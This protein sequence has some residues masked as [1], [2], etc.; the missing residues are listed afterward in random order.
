[1]EPRSDKTAFAAAILLIGALFMGLGMAYPA[2]AQDRETFVF[3]QPPPAPERARTGP[4]GPI[5]VVWWLES[6]GSWSERLE[7]QG[8]AHI[9]GNSIEALLDIPGEDAPIVFKTL[10]GPPAGE[11]SYVRFSQLGRPMTAPTALASHGVNYLTRAGRSVRS[12]GHDGGMLLN[13]DGFARIDRAEGEL[14]ITV[15]VNAVSCLSATEPP[16]VSVAPCDQSHQLSARPDGRANVRVCIVARERWDDDPFAC[17]PPFRVES[18]RPEPERENVNFETPDLTVTFSEPVT[19]PSLTRAFSLYTYA[20]DGDQLKIEG[21]WDRNGASGYRFSPEEPLYSGTIY[22][23]RIESG[24]AGVLTPEGAML[25]EDY[26]WS[27]VT[28]LDLSVQA[29]EDES[30]VQLHTFQVVRNAFL[31]RD[32]PT[33][34]RAY[35]TWE[36]HEDVA[37]HMQPDSFPMQLAYSEHHPRIVGQFRRAPRGRTL[38]VW[39]H[40]DDDIFSHDDRRHARHTINAFGWRPGPDSGTL[41]LRI[42]PDDPFPQ[43]L[44][45]TR[46][47]AER[48]YDV[49][50]L[51][52]GELSVVYAVLRIGDWLDGIPD[53]KRVLMLNSVN[54]ASTYVPQY[55]PHR[56]TR[57]RFIRH[58]LSYVH[59]LEALLRDPAMI[60]AYG[61]V[62]V[63]RELERI[64]AAVEHNLREQHSSG[65]DISTPGTWEIFRSV[66]RGDAR[67]DDSE[68]ESMPN[69]V[70]LGAFAR[71]VQERLGQELGPDDM[72]AIITPPLFLGEATLGRAL[73]PLEHWTVKGAFSNYQARSIM[74]TM[75]AG[76]TA[77]EL[78][79]GLVHEFA[80]AFGLP[81]L[82]GNADQVGAASDFNLNIEAYRIA[83]SG[84]DGWNKSATEGNAQD[85][86]TLVSLMWPSVLPSAASSMHMA[87][88]RTVQHDIR[89]GM[90]P[91]LRDLMDASLP[92]PTRWAQARPG[93]TATDAARPQ[94]QS[95]AIS[96]WM[97]ADD[98]PLLINPVRLRN[99]PPVQSDAGRFRAVLRDD[100]GRILSEMRF[101]PRPVRGLPAHPATRRLMH[102]DNPLNPLT[103]AD[104]AI[105]LPLDPD[106]AQIEILDGTTVIA[107]LAPQIDGPLGLD[108]S[109]D[110]SG[111]LKWAATGAPVTGADIHYS[112]TGNAPWKPLFLHQT[113]PQIELDLTE[114]SDGPA[115]RLRVTVSDGL[116]FAQGEVQLAPPNLEWPA[117][118]FP[119]TG[120]FTDGAP[121]TLY[122][123]AAVDR[124][125]LATHLVVTDGTGQELQTELVVNDATLT[126]GLFLTDDTPVTGALTLA[127]GR[128]LSSQYGTAI[129]P[130]SWPVPD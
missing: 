86:N 15:R 38:R 7:G 39:R 75:N 80:H 33:L 8:R 127:I 35:V 55:L 69:T 36:R 57:T 54:M 107:A 48:E 130:I 47:S 104:F 118:D 34:T 58:S 98:G 19:L 17:D 70:L 72:L 46:Y 84:L 112:P 68:W 96:G 114:L 42:E 26:I 63:M 110:P 129:P 77:D 95:L 109:L 37:H 6:D 43:P 49:W 5:P 102:L 56:G 124:A 30:P 41:R 31:T 79:V 44:E 123:P 52:P 88:Y 59:F 16:F 51:D 116:R 22:R 97:A 78:G 61:G 13:E 113:A 81:H 108:L 28:M 64:E 29:P 89:D 76:F 105:S 91:G 92:R 87:E 120:A 73:S 101:D 4:S 27:F 85:E 32:K 83:P 25:D 3:E 117:P 106:A 24:G 20:P 9:V 122:L 45:Q 62:L 71:W 21:T 50:E 128:G 126:A 115:P 74:M 121:I 1:M 103:W 11:T 40:D 66:R 18:V 67:Y 65:G 82:P 14:A 60:A 100:G 12:L 90:R 93:T 23:A 2:V 53:D 111:M 10:G 119:D 99:A 94:V 125:Q